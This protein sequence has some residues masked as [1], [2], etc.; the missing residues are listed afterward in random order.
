MLGLMHARAATASGAVR[1]TRE[2]TRRTTPCV[3]LYDLLHRSSHCG[4][5]AGIARCDR[6]PQGV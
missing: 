4:S 5:L 3:R 1:F 2:Q 6:Q